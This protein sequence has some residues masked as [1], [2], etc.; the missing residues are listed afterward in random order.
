M[1]QPQYS[2]RDNSNVKSTDSVRNK[3]DKYEYRWGMLEKHP[4]DE[5]R[6]P[7][8]TFADFPWPSH[9]TLYPAAFKHDNSKA[10]VDEF[11]RFLYHP[12][13]LAMY[14]YPK[15]DVERFEQGRWNETM[16]ENRVIKK[17][18]PQDRNLEMEVAMSQSTNAGSNSE[19]NSSL[20]STSQP[21]DDM[22][23][24]NVLGDLI[25][26]QSAMLPGGEANG[27]IV[28]ESESGHDLT[29]LVLPTSSPFHIQP[30]HHSSQ[31][32]LSS[33]QTSQDDNSA[34]YSEHNDSFSSSQSSQQYSS[35]SI[36]PY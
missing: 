17:V 26:S 11:L 19:I 18:L 2:S 9:R 29:Q 24:N 3:Y 31:E 30:V 27:S 10:I 7:N 1:L 4:E 33:S 22:S 36:I 20:P 12:V 15:R 23:M 13:R 25:S 14:S 8:M 6:N 5:L 21:E 32:E 16:L 28:D 35:Q 34:D